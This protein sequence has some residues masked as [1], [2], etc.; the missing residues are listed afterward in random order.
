V[1][2]FAGTL[3]ALHL[4]TGVV[5]LAAAAVLLVV[6]FRNVLNRSLALFL[7]LEGG[8]QVLRGFPASTPESAALAHLGVRMSL[9]A[10][11][12]MLYFAV[13]YRDRYQGARWRRAALPLLVVLG[14]VFVLTGTS[15]DEAVGTASVLDA[16]LSVLGPALAAVVLAIDATRAL[17]ATRR[18]A[19]FL[20]SLGFGFFSF[21]YGLHALVPGLMDLPWLEV[22]TLTT[23]VVPLVSVI[24]WLWAR[25]SRSGDVEARRDARRYV[26]AYAVPLVALVVLALVQLAAPGVPARLTMYAMMALWSVLLALLVVYA[27]LRQEIFGVDARVKWGISRGT[28]AAVF[29]LAFFVASQLAQNFLSASFGWAAG[30]IVAGGLLFAIAPLQRFAERV[31]ES[32]MP[33]VRDHRIMTLDDRREVYRAQV[34]AAWEDG[35]LTRDERRMLDVAR[36]RLGIPDEEAARIEREAVGATA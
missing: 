22:V 34:A 20:G 18:R 4:L 12:A 31:A 26:A 32:A 3:L 6:D 23:G 33:G 28:V 19:L 15:V 7:V 27:V 17:H 14:L 16:G 8:Y 1:D 36:E 21:S 25:S 10:P 5:Y 29:L 9:A 30:G 35:V 13:A 2:A 24:A 11:S